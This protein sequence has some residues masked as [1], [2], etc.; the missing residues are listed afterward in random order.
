MSTQTPTA[1]APRPQP[2]AEP[3]D[4]LERFIDQRLDQARRQVKGVDLAAALMRLAVGVLVYVLLVSVLDHWVFHGGLGFWGRL[5]AFSLLVGAAGW[6]AVRELIP[7]L[8]KRVNPIFAAYTIEQ[9]KPS[10]KNSLINFLLL[11]GRRRE[12]PRVIYRALEH[13]AV[14]DLKQVEIEAAVDRAHVLRLGYVLAA[15]FALFCLY[16]ILSPKSPMV[17]AARLLAPWADIPPPARVH[18]RNVEPGDAVVFQLQ[19]STAD[20]QSTDQVVPLTKDEGDYRHHCTIPPSSRGFQQHW[21]YRLAAGDAL[22]RWYD[23]RVEVPPIIEIESIRYD[24]P[25][26]TGL[27]PRTVARQGDIRALEGTRVTIHGRANRPMRRAEI[28]LGC[29]GRGSV[30]MKVNQRAAVGSFQLRF[31]P[32]DSGRPAHDCYQLR[33]VDQQGHW[34][35]RPVCGPKIPTSHFVAWWCAA[36]ARASRCLHCRCSSG[37]RRARRGKDPWKGLWSFGRI[38][39]GLVPAMW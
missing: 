24:Y 8:V 29:D 27:P 4:P 14:T 39:W 1:E 17:S 18:I 12:M 11:R 25:A 22:T 31:S 5:V 35:P 34:N 10:I 38:N 32:S 20:G 16:L 2:P 33:F 21:R 23:I 9:S 19:Y 37:A 28:D 3:P 13:R 7:P 6:Y 26:Y 30:A 36:A 15:T